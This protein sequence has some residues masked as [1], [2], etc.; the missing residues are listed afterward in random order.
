MKVPAPFD[1]AA[2]LPWPTKRLPRAAMRLR[3]LRLPLRHA[4]AICM[5][6]LAVVVPGASA[7]TQPAVE[8]VPRAD[9]KASQHVDRLVEEAEAAYRAQR[10]QEAFAAFGRLIA[11]AP[12]DAH[13]WLRIGNLWQR[14]GEPWRAAEAYRRAVAASRADA[15]A[16]PDADRHARIEASLQ[17]RSKAALNL[18]SLGVEQVR[19][20][21]ASVDRT[22]LPAEL[23]P[24][25]EGLERRLRGLEGAAHEPAR[26]VLR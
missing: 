20:A 18:A 7:Q 2:C 1:A 14:N 25:A 24:V 15:A 9:L 17:A 16:E 5:L 10:D 26:P 3:Q 6:G 11:V 19:D 22:R 8:A 23:Q 21:L 12:E 4:A 13:A